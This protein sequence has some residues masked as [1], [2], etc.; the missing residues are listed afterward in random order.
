MGDLTHNSLMSADLPALLIMGIDSRL[1]IDTFADIQKRLV[2]AKESID[3]TVGGQDVKGL[4]RSGE[5]HIFKLGQHGRYDHRLRVKTP[6]PSNFC[7]DRLPALLTA[8]MN[9]GV[10]GRCRSGA[11]YAKA[12]V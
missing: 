3:A 11:V 8:L 4:T 5:A 12:T 6:G 2:G 7:R 10:V 9:F 1:D